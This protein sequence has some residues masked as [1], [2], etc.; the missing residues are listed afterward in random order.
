MHRLYNLPVSKVLGR[1]TLQLTRPASS[2]N[3]GSGPMS[4]PRRVWPV[5]SALAL[6]ICL[7]CDGNRPQD[8][9]SQSGPPATGSTVAETE[10][11]KPR[12]TVAGPAVLPQPTRSQGPVENRP[13]RTEWG[14][15][16]HAATTAGPADLQ[17]LTQALRRYSAEKRRVP[18]NLNELVSAGYLRE[19]PAPPPGMQYAIHSARVEVIL[20][21]R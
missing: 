14:S 5:L 2:G 4:L 1:S 18:A 15:S 13:G 6:T 21:K 3:A 8:S 10:T 12:S 17:A 19:L 11:E 7:G 16:P 20:V 9:Q